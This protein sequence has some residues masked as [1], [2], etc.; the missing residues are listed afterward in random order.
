MVFSERYWCTVV[1]KMGHC[2]SGHAKAKGEWKASKKE[3]GGRTP[4]ATYPRRRST[5]RAS[6][7]EDNG[8]LSKRCAALAKEQRARFYI[9]RRCITLLLCWHIYGEDA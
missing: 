1:K 9:L 2:F 6:V 3:R 7:Q 8:C 5:K 4:V